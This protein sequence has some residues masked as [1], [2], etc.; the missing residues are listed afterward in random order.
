MR[1]TPAGPARTAVLVLNYNG[2]Q[3]LE[4][5]LS[6]LGRL[7]VFTP[8][9]AGVPRDPAV[10]DE[11]WLVDNGSSDD[12]VALVRARFPW[13]TALENG[14]NLG[15][16]A[17]N[18]RAAAAAPSHFVAF[19]NNDTRVA[20]DWLSALHRCQTRHP[21]SAAVASCIA[22]WDGTRT[23][24]VGADTFF[25]GHA[26]QRGVGEP[27][28][29]GDA[30]ERRLLFG[31]AGSLLVD[32]EKFLEMGAFDP[33][34]FS[35]FED[36][37]LGW[38]ANLLGLDTWFAP[39]ALTFHRLHASWGDA[40]TPRKRFLLE[41]N[42][43][44]TVFKNYG[45]ERA[46]VMLL[47]AAGLAFLRGWWAGRSTPA[48]G[49][50]ETTDAL[51]H[52]L[53]IAAVG[54]RL[55]ALQERRD[56]AQSRR[57]RTDEDLFPLFGGIAAM[58]MPAEADYRSD[59]SSA[60]SQVLVAGGRAVARWDPATNLAARNAF[61][62]L[63]RLCEFAVR[64][65]LS[66]GDLDA[67]PSLD[68]RLALPFAVTSSLA[69]ARRALSGFLATPISEVGCAALARELDE[70]R[71]R[72]VEGGVPATS[73]HRRAGVA[74]AE[75]VA[76][77]GE[78]PPISLVIRTQ[79]RPDA[80]R[81][82]LASVA[83][84][85]LLPAEV[86]L[87]ND[88]GPDP[89]SVLA[90][91]GALRVRVVGH[92]RPLGR[93]RAAQ[94]GLEASRGEY[95]GFLDD[96]DVLAPNHFAVLAHG[97]VASGLPVA[98]SDV[99]C[100]VYDRGAEVVAR[101][102]FGDE[103]DPD[104]LQFENTIPIM[105]VLMRRELALAAGG[106]DPC[107]EYF[108]DWDLWLRLARRTRFHHCPVITATYNVRPALGQGTATSGEHRWKQLARLFDKHRDAVT[109]D[110]WAAYYRSYVEPSRRRVSEA[111]ANLLQ[112]GA[113]LQ[114]I[115]SALAASQQR[116]DELEARLVDIQGSRLWRWLGWLWRAR[117]AG[118]V[119]AL[120]RGVGRR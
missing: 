104:R 25:T 106:F 112:F 97:L 105:A 59:F 84:Q 30:P 34:Y 36:V 52:L 61:A 29:A 62:A 35:F 14:A 94:A 16:S 85:S 96:D 69:A 26:L 71:P 73:T 48:H 17:G 44:A 9:A 98:Y 115:E 57:R 22:S 58:P 90:D 95:V 66:P 91:F 4:D 24:F 45:E 3:H 83:A 80:L 114:E 23:D 15:F 117:R 108:E 111:E 107:L 20:P 42:A 49:V 11:V 102:V 113:T 2:R 12:S 32:R 54:D 41:R 28:R 8:G 56:A 21:E 38:R 118:L 110:A 46:G 19:L 74:P 53:A 67:I 103:F 68:V 78:L 6:S 10:R 79:D 39:E 7:D 87:V 89:S 60:C 88:G 101:S 51:C 119:Q 75:A 37:D 63:A 40:L 81:V 13:V 93:S 72:S 77:A 33:D 5:C 116:G 47:V 64:R 120:R 100:V 1:Q 65:H 31:C 99:E 86:V 43:L 55:A 70:A 92:D 18:N 82:A 109:G 50:L 27:R 76:R